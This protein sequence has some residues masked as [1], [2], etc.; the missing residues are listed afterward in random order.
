MLND[1]DDV[2][3]FKRLPNETDE[4]RSVRLSGKKNNFKK[5]IRNALAHGMCW[6]TAA[7]IV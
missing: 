7:G 3:I 1:E 2:V 6:T 4:Q 5:R